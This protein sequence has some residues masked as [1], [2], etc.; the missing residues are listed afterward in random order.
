MKSVLF[1]LGLTVL[2]TF[3]HAAGG[4][5]V[6]NSGV[7]TRAEAI[8]RFKASQ[9]KGVISQ[10]ELLERMQNRGALTSAECTF[11]AVNLSDMKNSAISTLASLGEE[12]GELKNLRVLDARSFCKNTK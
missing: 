6:G 8:A 1:A 11:Y 2:S 5:D 3:A 12:A 4:S 10:K 9:I 7:E